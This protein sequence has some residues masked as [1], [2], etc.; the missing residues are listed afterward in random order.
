MKDWDL[1]KSKLQKRKE[2][3]KTFQKVV[4]NKII[5]DIIKLSLGNKKLFLNECL[6][7]HKVVIK[8]GNPTKEGKV[9]YYGYKKSFIQCKGC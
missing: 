7:R 3:K 4:D 2:N 6:I 5:F 1:L 8:S 9:I